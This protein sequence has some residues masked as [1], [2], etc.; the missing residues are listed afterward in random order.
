[1]KLPICELDFNDRMSERHYARFASGEY[2]A[3]DYKSL[4]ISL[5][6]PRAASR[7][8]LA[9]HYIAEGAG[10]FYSQ[11]GSNPLLGLSS[12]IRPKTNFGGPWRLSLPRVGRAS[13]PNVMRI[14]GADFLPYPR[15]LSESA[16]LNGD[17]SD[18]LLFR[19]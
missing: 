10:G 19:Y 2:C 4:Q 9:V 11:T 7:L 3:R 15:E 6:L 8:R 13:K 5:L 12:T 17:L 1:M 18:K 14:F 16:P